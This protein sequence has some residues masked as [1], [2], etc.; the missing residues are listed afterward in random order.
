MCEYPCRFSKGQEE[1]NRHFQFILS[2]NFIFICCSSCG[3]AVYTVMIIFLYFGG[4]CLNGYKIFLFWFYC[5]YFSFVE[6]C[7]S[8]PISFLNCHLICFQRDLE[9]Y[10]YHYR[11]C[12]QL[13]MSVPSTAEAVQQRATRQNLLSQRILLCLFPNLSI[14]VQEMTQNQVWIMYI[15][16]CE[17]FYKSLFWSSTITFILVHSLRL[18]YTE[19]Y[20]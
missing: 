13:T 14:M 7:I 8:K 4:I 18:K 17:R 3:L 16:I 1:E 5:F 10:I 9:C 2:S 12:G 11:R 19:N 15:F 6:S 20:R